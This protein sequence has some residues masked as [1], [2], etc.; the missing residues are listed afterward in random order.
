M[1]QLITRTNALVIHMCINGFHP[2]NT[3]YF[4]IPL[5]DRFPIQTGFAC[6]EFINLLY[7][8][9]HDGKQSIDSFF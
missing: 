6:F 4:K 3:W 9:S 5:I 1:K 2:L 7:F 8:K